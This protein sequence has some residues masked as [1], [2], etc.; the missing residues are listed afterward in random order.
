[1]ICL[2]KTIRYIFKIYLFLMEG[3]LLYSIVL[4]SAKD[5]HESAIG[6]LMSSPSSASLPPPA[7]PT[8]GCYRAPV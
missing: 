8:L 2:L 5:Q 7:P 6:V 1:M 4:V 3:Y